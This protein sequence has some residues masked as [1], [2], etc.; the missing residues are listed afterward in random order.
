MLLN[1][2][3]PLID[4][5]RIDEAHK[6]G[7]DKGASTLNLVTLGLAETSGLNEALGL[8]DGMKLPDTPMTKSMATGKLVEEGGGQTVGDQPKREARR[9]KISKGNKQFRV[10]LATTGVNTSGGT[11]VN[12]GES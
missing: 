11:G 1:K 9:K 4:G 8:S 12:V 2:N 7:S 10:P 6:G 3:V 5:M